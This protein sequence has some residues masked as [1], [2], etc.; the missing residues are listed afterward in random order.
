MPTKT[1][2]PHKFSQP[3]GGVDQVKAGALVFMAER[4]AGLEWVLGEINEKMLK[5]EN[6]LQQINHKTKP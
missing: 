6:H 5:M 4:L 2:G 3:M 1:S